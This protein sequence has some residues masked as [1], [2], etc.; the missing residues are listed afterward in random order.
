MTKYKTYIDMLK[1]IKYSDGTKYQGNPVYPNTGNYGLDFEIFNYVINILQSFNEKSIDQYFYFLNFAMAQ[2]K[3]VYPLEYSDFVM[4][5]PNNIHNML[6]G[7]NNDFKVRPSLGSIVEGYFMVITKKHLLS[8]SELNTEE[9]SNYIEL[10][11]KYRQFLYE[12]YGKYP[13]IFEHGSSGQSE[14]K[15]NSVEHAH[16]HIVN[17]HYLNQTQMLNKMNFLKV[18]DEVEALSAV[19]NKDYIFYID[20]LGDVYYTIDYTPESQIMRKYIANDIGQGEKW[21]WREYPF[22]ENIWDSLKQVKLN[23]IK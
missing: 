13:I 10:L 17:H 1:D 22:Y 6:I 7:E 12:I 9:I 20:N 11:K 19:K 23:I 2:A 8:M 18:G 3:E 21:N 4:N 15:T 5:F 14:K 16:T